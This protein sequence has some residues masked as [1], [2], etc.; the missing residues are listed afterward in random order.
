MVIGDEAGS[1]L[2]P[3]VQEIF[4]MASRDYPR[5]RGHLP[6]EISFPGRLHLSVGTE[7]PGEQEEGKDR[8]Y[9]PAN[10]ESAFLVLVLFRIQGQGTCSFYHSI[11]YRSLLLRI[12]R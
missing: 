8:E 5:E 3:R 11:S 6:V 4:T 2:I 9:S 12:S 1:R 7:Y 10:R